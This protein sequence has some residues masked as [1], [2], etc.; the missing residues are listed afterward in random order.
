MPLP[1][2]SC[3]IA[4]ETSQTQA[5]VFKIADQIYDS[6]DRPRIST[7]ESNT[8]PSNNEDLGYLIK[9]LTKRI[10][11]LE[12]RGSGQGNRF[13]SQSRNQG[14]RTNSQSRPAD[15]STSR[16]CWYHK[17][18]SENASK[19]IPPCQY[20]NAGSENSKN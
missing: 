14:S 9:N 15:G 7:V 4:I 6:T 5:E 12:S 1:I 10:S 18:Y 13:R 17:K 11:R 8:R 20:K 3:V 2:R 16:I 19:C